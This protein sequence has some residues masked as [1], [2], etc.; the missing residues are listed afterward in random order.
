MLRFTDHIT[1]EP[2]RQRLLDALNGRGAFRRFRDIVFDGPPEV[3]TQWQIYR[4]E[5]PR[6]CPRMVRPAGLPSRRRPVTTGPAGTGPPGR[7][8]IPGQGA[9]HSKSVACYEKARVIAAARPL[10]VCCARPAWRIAAR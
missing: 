3:L 7:H 4:Q 8:R 2:L 5:R 1:S 9:A 10:Q 6:P